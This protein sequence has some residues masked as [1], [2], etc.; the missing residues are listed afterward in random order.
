VTPVQ[1]APAEEPE[2]EDFKR[3]A[4]AHLTLGH[5]LEGYAVHGHI[6]SGVDDG[7]MWVHLATQDKGVTAEVLQLHALLDNRSARMLRN[8]WGSVDLRF[9]G[10]F[11]GHHLTIITYA[12]EQAADDLVATFPG[13]RSD[14]LPVEIEDLERFVED[15]E[16]R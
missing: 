6:Q 5:F 3:F 1:E 8:T 7:G 12:R 16:G 4:E 13:V 11:D 10:E 9:D 15:G 2:A 14:F